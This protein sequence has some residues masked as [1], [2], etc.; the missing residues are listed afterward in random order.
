MMSNRDDSNLVALN[1]VDQ[2]IGEIL[3]RQHSCVVST[4]FAHRR[5]VAQ[6]RKRSVGCIG[7]ILRGDVGTF[8][9]VPV[10]SSIGVGLRFFAKTDS[11]QLG[12]RLFLRGA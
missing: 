5:K 1:T 11:H 10:D 3:K 2:R 12:R 4:L 8:S 7:K 6:Q 9:K